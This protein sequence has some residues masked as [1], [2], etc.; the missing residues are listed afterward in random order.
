MEGLP[1]LGSG[2]LDIVIRTLV[3]YVAVRRSHGEGLTE[4]VVSPDEHR[5]SDVPRFRRILVPMKLGVIGEEMAATAER[6][7]IR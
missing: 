7:D 4:R 6:L 1:G 2:P 5:L 3:V